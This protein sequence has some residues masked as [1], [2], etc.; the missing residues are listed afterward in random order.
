MG[1]LLF[2]AELIETIENKRPGK[3]NNADKRKEKTA[4][5]LKEYNQGLKE[6]RTDEKRNNMTSRIAP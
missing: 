2:D 6:R 1:C 5:Y 4:R 3:S